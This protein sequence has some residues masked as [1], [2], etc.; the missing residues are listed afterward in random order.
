MSF[1][2]NFEITKANGLKLQNN[3]PRDTFLQDKISIFS[4]HNNYVNK[5]QL[6]DLLQDIIDMLNYDKITATFDI[7]DI[8][9]IIFFNL[10]DHKDIMIDYYDIIL[11]LGGIFLNVFNRP[12]NRLLSVEDGINGP[13]STAQML[14][15]AYKELEKCKN[16]GTVPYGANLIFATLLEKDLK[17]IVKIEYAKDWLS[18]L[19][20]QIDAGQVVF[21]ANDRDYFTYLNFQF[22]LSTTEST[23]VYDS[24]KATTSEFYQF[25][26]KY[27]IVPAD[28]NHKRFINNELTLNQFLGSTF[29][30]AKIQPAY[31]AI[32]KRLFS[33]G[34]LNLRNNLAHCNFGYLNYHT[35]CVGAL[36][37]GLF[38]MIST[39]RCL[40]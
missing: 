11:I 8:Q 14:I 10:Q 20:Q 26:C 34:C 40:N 7:S 37:Y 21:D 35:S 22:E 19:Q 5:N 6:L 13:I 12:G 39:R 38:S 17:A 30:I 31:L 27:N 2:K 4:E 24:V 36:L 25:L 1:I 3:Q 32:T 33:T 29:C 15:V 16:D 28:K 9:D 23:S 18:T